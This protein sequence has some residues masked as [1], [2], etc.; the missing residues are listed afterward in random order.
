MVP[1]TLVNAIRRASPEVADLELQM[2][3]LEPLSGGLLHLEPIEVPSVVRAG[4]KFQCRILVENCSPHRMQSVSPNPVHFSYH[5]AMSPGG[6]VAVFDG[7]RTRLSP[8]VPGGKRVLQ[9]VDI[10]APQTAGRYLLQLTLV[11][12]RVR[13]FDEPPTNLSAGMNIL[14][15]N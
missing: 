5:W 10:H 7:V 8:T 9:T 2:L 12:E 3:P 4:S 15:L 6:E 1:D 13:W 11:Q 14:V